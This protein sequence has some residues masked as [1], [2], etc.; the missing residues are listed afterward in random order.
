MRN[1]R[2]VGFTCQNKADVLVNDIYVD[3]YSGDLWIATD[4]GLLNAKHDGESEVYFKDKRFT[5]I[6]FANHACI[7]LLSGTSIMLLQLPDHIVSCEDF[8]EN[9]QDCVFSPDLSVGVILTENCNIF[10]I[11]SEIEIVTQI[12]L[13][14]LSNEKTK[15]VNVGWGKEETQFKGRK[16]KAPNVDEEEGTTEPTSVNILPGEITWREDS[17]YFAVSWTDTNS[18]QAHRRLHIFDSNGT[19]NSVGSETSEVESGLCWRPRV[20]L[21]AASKRLSGRL[22]K[23]VF[24]ELN[25]L[26]HGEIDLLYAPECDKFRVGRIVFDAEEH[27]MAVLFLPLESSVLPFVRLYT[28]SNYHWSVKGELSPLPTPLPT[29]PI[30]RISLTFGGGG[31]VA[32]TSTLHTAVSL[33]KKEGSYIASFGLASCIDRSAWIPNST[34][35]DPAI[36][37]NIDGN[38]VGLT[39]FAFTSIPPPMAGS[40]I[41]FPFTVSAV[42]ISQPRFPDNAHSV[43][44]QPACTS[45]DKA[46]WFLTLNT[47][48]KN[49]AILKSGDQV[50]NQEKGMAAKNCTPTVTE[51]CVLR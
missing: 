23:V 35:P 6:A 7:C 17:K 40:T 36:L 1:L 42:T 22:L 10:L 41:T 19:L 24:F 38:S 47:D 45:V 37:A 50:L 16:I 51:F 2:T 34:S 26:P 32:Q 31:D 49:K 46:P 5:K 25:G 8:E 39:A 29:S 43:L 27:I 12:D 3:K 28:T 9:I 21:I 4:C 13:S 11:S 44:V 33:G 20:Q 30:G 15:F 14:C 48:W 18:P